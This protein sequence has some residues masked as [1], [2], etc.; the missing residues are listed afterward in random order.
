MPLVYM[1]ITDWP[2]LDQELWRR[3]LQPF[4][5]FASPDQLPW[6][7][8][9]SRLGK[10]SIDK[11]EHGYGRWLSFL[12]D[13]G[14]LDPA[15]HPADRATRAR[16]GGYFEMLL[17]RGNADSTVVSLFAD[18]QRALRIMAPERDHA[19]IAKPN[20]ITI[21]SLL[22]MAKRSFPV[23][24]ASVLY[25]WGLEHL[26]AA[27]KGTTRQR[28][29]ALR[30]GVL[31]V[32]LASRAR[33]LRAMSNLRLGRELRREG[34]RYLVDLPPEL[35]KTKRRDR[36][37]LPDRLTPYIDR[38]LDEVRPWLMRGKHHDAVWVNV[39]GDPLAA[40][41]LTGIIR[42]GSRQR[43]DVAF[44]IHRFRHAVG[45]TV[46]LR[47]PQHPGLAAAIM[48][49]SPGVL[50]DAYNRAGQA[51][52]TLAFQEQ[53][54]AE[55]AEAVEE[56]ARRLRRRQGRPRLPDDDSDPDAGGHAAVDSRPQEP[57]P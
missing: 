24:D 39:D 6:A 21:R 53:R 10:A 44:G 28:A 52:A 54:E 29:L 38:Y 40:P 32:A 47:L 9:A 49:V 25:G 35:V 2:A 19:D 17:E 45:T 43:F 5:P 56:H 18:L 22:P 20:G 15:A 7:G 13:S 16:R 3:G 4:D 36:F 50:E 12:R 31:I 55:Q 37:Y 46:P 14:Q 51:A 11:A 57:K 48:D 33:R 42:R 27:N 41:G 8:Y 30:D 34:D 23:P 1:P 26:E